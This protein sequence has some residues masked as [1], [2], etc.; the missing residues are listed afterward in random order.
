MKNKRLLIII[1][2]LGMLSSLVIVPTFQAEE[3]MY[4][5]RYSGDIEL[6]QELYQTYVKFMEALDSGDTNQIKTFCLPHSIHIETALRLKENEEYGGGINL[7]F[8]K[9]RFDKD[10]L[11]IRKDNESTYL[12]RTGTSYLYFVDTKSNS[13]MLYK[14]GDKPIR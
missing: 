13:W 1:T 14:Y 5:S 4:L 7:W 11:S 3:G 12:I 2:F 9:T 10:I 6:P 8:V